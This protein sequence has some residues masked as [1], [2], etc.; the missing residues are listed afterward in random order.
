MKNWKNTFLS[1]IDNGANQAKGLVESFND[2]VNSFDWDSQ[3]E[4]LKERR[5]SLI[6]KSN[7]L[8]KDFSELM[9]QVKDNLADF[10]I[11]VP[12][13]ES[14]GEEL[15]CE[16]DGDNNKLNIEVNFSNETTTKNYKTTV[17]LPSNCDLEKLSKKV[18]NAE[19]TVTITIP[20]KVKEPIEEVVEEAEKPN[21]EETSAAETEEEQEA[22]MH[23]SS[24]LARKIQQNV[25]KQKL[26]RDPN[27]RF[28]RR[29]VES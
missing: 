18:N 15:T 25:D 11:T 1:L 24:K 14:T 3:F 9:K 17:L 5:K 8:F 28:V 27:G 16:I 21:E 12:F 19:K 6:E 22:P 20:K 7:E 13:D 10:S 26:H 2:V 23:I 4:Y 29:I